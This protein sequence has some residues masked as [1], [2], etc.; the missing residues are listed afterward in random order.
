M[1]YKSTNDSK[2]PVDL[3]CGYACN[4]TIRMWAGR[5]PSTNS[6][7][8]IW[9]SGLHLIDA[10]EHKPSNQ[11]NGH[12]LHTLNQESFKPCHERGGSELAMGLESQKATSTQLYVDRTPE[13]GLNTVFSESFLVFEDSHFIS[14]EGSIMGSED[15]MSLK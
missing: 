8:I 10:M 6:S 1:V 3:D 5:L 7:G 2:Y 4:A 9:H 11:S 15:C 13:R 12:Y 14:S